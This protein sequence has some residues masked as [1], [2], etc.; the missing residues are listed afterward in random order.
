MSPAVLY[1]LTF[2]KTPLLEKSTFQPPDSGSVYS[3]QDNRHI[4]G[5]VGF[6][7][8]FPG[9]SGLFFTDINIQ[10]EA[11]KRYIVKNMD[12]FSSSLMSTVNQNSIFLE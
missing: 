11:G 1:T 10:D 9:D 2:E 8:H 4:E 7:A 6:K 5:S 3:T 12:F